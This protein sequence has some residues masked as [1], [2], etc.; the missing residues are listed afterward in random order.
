MAVPACFAVLTTPVIAIAG[1]T[2][3]QDE[4]ISRLRQGGF[5]LVMRHA[6]S[7]RE[8]PSKDVAK[9]R[10]HEAATTMGEVIRAL[11]IPIGIVLTG[12]TFTVRLPKTS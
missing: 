1:Q 8:T 7:P 2:S 11:R 4:L 5:V 3:S 6:S 10:Q 12:T 9:C